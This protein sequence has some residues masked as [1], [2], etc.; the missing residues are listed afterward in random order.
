MVAC[1]VWRRAKHKDTATGVDIRLG[2]ELGGV[3]RLGSI[4][5]S[6]DTVVRLFYESIVGVVVIIV[7]VIIIIVVSLGLLVGSRTTLVYQYR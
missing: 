6:T 5:G 1:C 7:V 4:D 2:S 3:S